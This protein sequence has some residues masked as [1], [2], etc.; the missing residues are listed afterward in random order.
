MP[1][2]LDLGGSMSLLFPILLIVI[3]VVLIIVPNRRREKKFKDMLSS[4]KVGDS[5]KTIGGIYGK[6]VNIKEDLITIESG[7][8]KTKLLMAKS[9]IGTVESNDVESEASKEQPKK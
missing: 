4:L 7:P 5:I 6:I 1:Q 3:F 9:A 2:Q 8:D